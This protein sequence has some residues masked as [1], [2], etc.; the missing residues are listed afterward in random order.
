MNATISG[1]VN[2]NEEPEGYDIFAAP[3]VIVPLVAI[4]SPGMCGKVEVKSPVIEGNSLNKYTTFQ[5]VG[6][7][8]LG[9]YPLAGMFDARKRYSDF[10]S[11]RELLNDIFPGVRLPALPRKKKDSGRFDKQ[12]IE[13]RRQG[14]QQFLERLFLRGEVAKHPSVIQFLKA[15]TAEQI[16]LVKTQFEALT[17][18]ERQDKY[19]S[20]FQNELTVL[21]KQDD[22][23]PIRDM[24]ELLDNYIT[25]LKEVERHFATIAKHERE[26]MQTMQLARKKL[27]QIN[28]LESSHLNAVGVPRRPRVELIHILGAEQMTNTKSE[29]VTANLDVASGV[30]VLLAAT[31]REVDDSQ[32]MIDAIASLGGLVLG[33]QDAKF[34][35]TDGEHKMRL[36]QEGGAASLTDL[37]FGKDKHAQIQETKFQIDRYSSEAVMTQ[38]FYAAARAMFISKEIPNFF[39]EKTAIGKWA[40]GEFA[41]RSQDRAD[42]VIALVRSEEQAPAPYTAGSTPGGGGYNAGGGIP[43]PALDNFD[44]DFGLT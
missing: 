22:D 7:L 44:D 23:Q 43:V 41:L 29:D 3:R 1:L 30:E 2:K 19:L 18:Q 35:V 38:E 25:H 15:S 28:K 39:R 34:Q 9:S 16:S 14:I 11:F 33:L 32:A 24:K 10:T 21:Q 8:D 26:Q 36:I 27:A 42:K 5:V 20:I 4:D 13:T 6:H 31:E 17:I 37:I 40:A 12:F